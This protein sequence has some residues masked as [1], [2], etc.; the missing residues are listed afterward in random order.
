[1]EFVAID[2]ETANSKLSSICQIGIAFYKDGLLADEWKS[3][4]NPEEHFLP[5]NISIHGINEAKV[6]DSPILPDVNGQ[7]HKYLGNRITVCHTFFDRAAIRQASA[8]YGV[9]EP[10]CRWLDSASVARRTWKE[11]SKSGYGLDKLCKLLKYN[12]AHHDALEDAKA[13]GYIMLSAIK[14]SGIDID[15]WLKLTGTRY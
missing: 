8:K 3:Y 13:A 11:C 4:I 5:F 12:F 14:E 6:K 9:T 1:M 15:G 2:V 10:D 7:L